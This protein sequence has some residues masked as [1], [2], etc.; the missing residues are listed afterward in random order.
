[1]MVV[2]LLLVLN[3]SIDV[4]ASSGYYRQEADAC[5]SISHRLSVKGGSK[6]ISY[7]DYDNIYQKVFIIQEKKR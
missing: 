7:K 1:M 4:S 6:S 5:I 2:S 3:F